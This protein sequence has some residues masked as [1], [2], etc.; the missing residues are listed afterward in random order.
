[1]ELLWHVGAAQINLVSFTVEN[2][3]WSNRTISYF[4]RKTGKRAVLRFGADAAVISN[5]LPRNGPLFPTWSQLSSADRADRF[6]R[7]CKSLGIAGVRLH[8]YRYAW[9]GRAMAAGYPALHA[10]AAMGH[11]SAAFHRAHAKGAQVEVSP[12]EEL[13]KRGDEPARDL[14]LA[15]TLTRP[16]QT[17]SPV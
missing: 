3:D 6:H 14:Q 9:V 4:R 5:C 15:D 1:M 2:V 8:S 7:R 17:K 11:S 16:A 12:L 10:Q 13:E